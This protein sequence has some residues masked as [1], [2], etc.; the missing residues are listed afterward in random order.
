[1][2]SIKNY[3]FFFLILLFSCG[4]APYEV[5]GYA[6]NFK[7]Y[8]V[9]GKPV[10]LEQYKGKAVVL[11]FWTDFCKSCRV[12]F[13]KLQEIYEATKTKNFELIAVNL[14]QPAKV[15]KTFQKDFDATFPMLVDEKNIMKDL[16][17]IKVYPTNVFINPEG[18]IV[19][20]IR[21][22]TSQQQVEV[23]VAQQ[24]GGVGETKREGKFK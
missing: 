8:D 5:G 14:G 7:L 24:S 2:L 23:F 9:A 12:E 17:N 20:I 1:M 18:K 15:S 11:H 10:S 19:R 13:P 16:Y 22:W 4:K 3:T 6:P 21:A